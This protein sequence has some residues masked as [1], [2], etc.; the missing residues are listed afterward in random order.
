MDVVAARLAVE[1]PGTNESRKVVLVPSNDVRLHPEVDKVLAPVAALL[2]VVPGLVLLIACANVANLLLARASGR[3]REVA[4]RLSIG[5]SR[6]RLVQQLLTESVTLSMAGGALGMALAYGLMRVAA[7]WRPEGLPVPLTLDLS[8]DARVVLF[9]VGLAVATG[10]IFGLAPAMQAT[11]PDLVPALKDEGASGLRAHRRY[12]LRNVLVVVQ[13]AV[14]LVLLAAAGLFV[15]SLQEAQF[16]EPGFESVRAVVLSPILSLTEPDPAVRRQLT[17]AIADRL[18]ALPGVERVALADRVPL[19]ASVRT[20]NF[21]PEGMDADADGRG[22][23]IDTGTIAPGYFA[24]M[25]IPL[26]AGRD[27]SDGDAEGA[28]PV[29]VVSEAFAR[30]FWPDQDPLGRMVRIPTRAGNDPAP[31]LQVVGV[32]RD[33]KVRTLGETPRPYVYRAW[34]QR[35][36]DDVGFVIRTSAA[37]EPLVEPARQAVLDIAPDAA[38]M[39]LQT[40]RQHLSLML[41]PPRLA[42]ALLGVCGLLALLLASVGLYAVVAYSVARRT[43]EIG[44]R[45]ALGAT[46]GSVIWLVVREGMALVVAGV[47]AGVIAA[48]VVAQPLSAYLYGVRPVDPLTFAAVAAVLA[49]VALVANYLPARRAVRVDPL[50]AIRYE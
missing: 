38:I 27:F 18:S 9:A 11:R 12:G 28:P 50:R 7:G 17:L 10:V 42:A 46:R 33:T 3:T 29:A 41:T 31:P 49:G 45:V 16:I 30:R 5:A 35:P 26:V 40:M 43:K 44:I 22:I 1:H 13:V 34:A 4:I 32:A 2:M 48:G 15:R 37:P 24:A 47:T 14:S 25:S 39:E 19:G 20:S 36:S 6:W 23:D 21:L 8:M